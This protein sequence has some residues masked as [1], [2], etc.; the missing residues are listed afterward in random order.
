MSA[1]LFLMLNTNA[2]NQVRGLTGTV[3]VHTTGLVS[4]SDYGVKSFVG[5]VFE[6]DTTITAI[7]P[8]APYQINGTDGHTYIAGEYLPWQFTAI[9]ITGSATLILGT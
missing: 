5:I 9:D 4:A 7:T 2:D 8:A 6:A 1:A 3:S